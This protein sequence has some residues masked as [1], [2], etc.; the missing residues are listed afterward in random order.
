MNIQTYL[1]KITRKEK[2]HFWI[3][4]SVLVLITMFVM[5][6]FSVFDLVSVGHDATFH[7]NRFISLSDAVSNGKFPV[8]IDY[9]AIDN[10][11]YATNLFY[12]NF[13][14]IP[15]AFISKYTGYIIAYQIMCFTYTILTGLFTYLCINKIFKDKLTAYLSAIIY[16]FCLYRLQ[17]Y[18][19][20]SAIAEAVTFTFLPLIF[21]G[22]YETLR[23]N[24]KK[25]YILSI[26]YS[27]FV[28]THILSTILISILIFIYIILSF[29][30]LKKEPFRIYYIIIS[31]SISILLSSYFILPFL[32][33]TISNSFNFEIFTNYPFSRVNTDDIFKVFFSLGKEKS[34]LPAI[35][36]TITLPLLCRFFIRKSDKI[37]KYIDY[38]AIAGLV[39]T[40]YTFDFLPQFLYNNY[41]FSRIQFLFR[42]Y[43][44]SSFILAIAGSYYLSKVIRLNTRNILIIPIFLILILT[45]ISLS[46]WNIFNYA[47]Y[48][49]VNLPE[50]SLSNNYFLGYADNLEYLPITLTTT[51]IEKRGEIIKKENTDTSINKIKRNRG[52]IEFNV[53]PISKD[54]LELPLTYYKGYT[55]TINNANIEVTKSKNGFVEIP[56]NQSGKVTVEFTGTFL[57][58]YS[59]YITLISIILLSIYIIIQNRKLQKC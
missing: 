13:T 44:F 59:I 42:I 18:F 6:R 40:L 49:I 43:E 7:Y 32:E 24:Y 31:I 9:E 56:V 36:L 10:Y 2:N 29:K 50:R 21:Y 46:S 55:A 5:Y 25:W 26:G 35:G 45:S 17:G 4:V 34:F 51:S 23:G 12:P 30:Y 11:G 41:I 16:T 37:T 54:V 8:Y 3:F 28:L 57:Q 15:F 48:G 39:L 27:L 20:R 14:L 58:K 38:L 52:K 22:L 47:K 53:N 33:Q 19:E 1:G